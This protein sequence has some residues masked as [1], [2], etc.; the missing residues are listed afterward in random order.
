MGVR[1]GPRSPA[2]HPSLR[3]RPSEPEDARV[4]DMLPRPVLDCLD[5][6]RT[7]LLREKER[8]S[9]GRWKLR[10]H[11][12]FSYHEISF[13]SSRKRKVTTQHPVEE[14]RNEGGTQR[15]FC[16]RVRTC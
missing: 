8:E 10:L 11:V 15:R 7:D 13:V 6:M 1:S 14:N 2:L 5:P 12:L 4:V 3:F 16:L 9:G